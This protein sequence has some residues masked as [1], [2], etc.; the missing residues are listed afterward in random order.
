MASAKQHYEELLSDVY[1]W[2]FGGFESGVQRNAAFFERLG[3]R[4]R[5]SATAFDLGAGCGF[6]SI[7][8]AR[9][10]FAVTAVDLDQKLLQELVAHLGPHSVST[11]QDDLLD[12]DRYVEGPVELVVCMTD[13]ILHLESKQDVRRLF[14]KVHA[15]L[16]P[17]GRFIVTF[18]DLSQELTDLDR[19]LPVRADDTTIFTCFLEY[20]PA[21]VKVHDLVYR[22]QDGAW[23]LHKS[24]YRKLR[25]SREWVATELLAAGFADVDMDVAQGGMIAA[26]ASR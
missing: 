20:E 21:S 18:R 22:K 7:P 6:Q 15:A 14:R 23:R 10:G 25:L 19:F 9:L 5:G 1:S 26:V 12:F 8:L 2:M 4:P 17:G 24:Y 16:E 13:T 11:V 3:I